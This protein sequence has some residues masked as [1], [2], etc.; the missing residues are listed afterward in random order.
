MEIGI[1]IHHYL[2]VITTAY[3]NGNNEE[4]IFMEISEYFKDILSQIIEEYKDL[5]I[6]VLSK[7]MRTY[8]P[9]GKIPT[10]NYGCLKQEEDDRNVIVSPGWKTKKKGSSKCLCGWYCFATNVNMWISDY[11]Y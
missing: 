11:K 2:L 7:N 10:E 9:S 4:E 1:D 5:K 6:I 8:L 3:L